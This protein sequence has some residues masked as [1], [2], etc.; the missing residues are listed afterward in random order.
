[1]TPTPV[2]AFTNGNVWVHLWP[3]DRAIRFTTLPPDTAV[4]ILGVY[5]SWYNVQWISEDGG[6]L[7]GWIYAPL[8]T[9]REELPASIF[10]PTATPTSTPRR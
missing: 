4:K 10:T 9:L 3:S 5:G 2:Q 6:L 1:V 8:I 7:G